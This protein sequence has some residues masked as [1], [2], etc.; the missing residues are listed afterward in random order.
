MSSVLEDKHHE[1]SQNAGEIL[2]PLPLERAILTNSVESKEVLYSRG[3]SLQSLKF[4]SERTGLHLFSN[5]KLT[6]PQKPE[7]RNSLE[8]T[9]DF[10]NSLKK[11]VNICAKPKI[12]FGDRETASE[13]NSEIRDYM[14]T[15]HT[16]NS[17]K[18]L[19]HLPKLHVLTFKKENIIQQ[20][21]CIVFTSKF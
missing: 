9:K 5:E 12:L 8:G 2:S 13:E 17:T 10:K 14:P 19:E 18:P 7:I 6:L 3:V 20:V 4:T 16:N 21:K 1:I 11:P 15:N